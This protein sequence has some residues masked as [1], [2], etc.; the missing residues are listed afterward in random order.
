MLSRLASEIK[1]EVCTGDLYFVFDNSVDDDLVFSKLS[2]VDVYNAVDKIIN[3]YLVYKCNICGQVY[4]YTYKNIE[5]IVR[6]KVMEKALAVLASTQIPSISNVCMDKFLIY[7][8]KCNGIDG[9]GCCTKSIYEKCDI[10]RF[11]I[12]DSKFS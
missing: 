3:R 2:G 8:G 10:K 5:G 12:Y 1:C 7:C 11:P 6:K 4:R 9:S